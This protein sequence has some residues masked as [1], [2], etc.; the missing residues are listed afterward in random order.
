MIFDLFT[1]LW[2]VYWSLTC[3]LIF[4]LFIDLLLIFFPLFLYLGLGLGFR[5]RVGGRRRERSECRMRESRCGAKRS[6]LGGMCVPPHSVSALYASSELRFKLRSNLSPLRYW[7]G[8]FVKPVLLLTADVALH[9]TSSD[10]G[11]LLLLFRGASAPWGRGR[12]LHGATWCLLW[13]PEHMPMS[14]QQRRQ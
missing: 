6:W 5:F 4:D 1:D 14:R 12:G 2:S 13:Y 8:A 9:G 7:L 3:L 11:L 10:E